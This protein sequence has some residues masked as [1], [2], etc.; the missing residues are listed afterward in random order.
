MEFRFNRRR[1]RKSFI[2]IRLHTDDGDD[3]AEN[4]VEEGE[5]AGQP[6]GTTLNFYA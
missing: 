1:R 4:E 3:E 5:R 2:L 6:S